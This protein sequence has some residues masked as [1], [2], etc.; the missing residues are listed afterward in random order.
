MDPGG[1]TSGPQGGWASQVSQGD[2]APHHAVGLG[3]GAGLVVGE[4]PRGE[5]G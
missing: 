2:A 5:I 1:K 3:L 4:H